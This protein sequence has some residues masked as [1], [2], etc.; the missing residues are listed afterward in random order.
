MLRVINMREVTQ[1]DFLK[2]VE[3]R[4][5]VEIG[6]VRFEIGKPHVIK[7]FQPRG[8]RLETTNVWSFPDRGEWATH[9]G[10]YRGN[11]PPQLVRNLLLRYT[12][13]GEVVLDP[14]AGSGTT[15]IEAKLLCRNAIGVDIS[16][17]AIMLTR[18]RLNFHYNPLDG[19]N[20]EI[21]TYVGDAR[22]LDLIEDNSVDLVALHPPYVDTIRYSENPL[23]IS[24][25]HD[26]DRYVEA[27]REVALEV[28]RVLKPGRYAAVLVGDTRRK[29]HHV[30]VA[31]RVMKAFLKTGFILKEDIIKI[32][33]NMKTTR[34]KWAK[35]RNED[36]WI[37]KD[38]FY[39]LTYEHLFIFRKAKDRQDI[40]THKDSTYL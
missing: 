32:Q 23:D 17:E 36:N 30:P 27:M 4:R 37:D 1:E 2:F 15:L 25:I 9:R 19:C 11:W 31:F 18:D 20:A 12:K 26:I 8:F 40:E 22:R 35:T 33:W 24:T 39:L 38:G 5:Y 10:D 14:M 34:E 16:L 28:H 7:E 3:T 21:K 6:G 13:P 29:R